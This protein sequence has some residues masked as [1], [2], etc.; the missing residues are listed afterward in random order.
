MIA[1]LLNLSINLLV[2]CLF[3]ICAAMSS[4]GGILLV[5]KLV[6]KYNERKSAVSTE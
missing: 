4:Y 6:G 3:A 1:F 5:D 2:I